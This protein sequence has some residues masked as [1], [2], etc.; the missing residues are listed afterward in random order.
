MSH[1]VGP[2]WRD[3]FEVIIC[4]AGKPD[5]FLEQNRPF[6]EMK[7]SAASTPQKQRYEKR[8]NWTSVDK[9]EKGKIYY[10]GCLAEFGRLTPWDQKS[11]L[12]FGDQINADLAEPSLRFGV[13]FHILLLFVAE[14]FG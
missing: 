10:E 5:F 3:A 2:D 7:E 12:Y 13:G 6:L 14:N 11:V 4:E 1:V 9:L 8:A